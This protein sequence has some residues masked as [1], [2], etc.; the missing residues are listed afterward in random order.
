MDRQTWTDQTEIDRQTDGQT[1]DR[2]RQTVDRDGQTVDK[3]M[4][5]P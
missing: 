1:V 3:Q 5:R 4:D 2:D